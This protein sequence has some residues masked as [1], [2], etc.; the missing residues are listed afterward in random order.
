MA[1]ATIPLRLNDK[2]QATPEAALRAAMEAL[3]A[4]RIDYTGMTEE[5]IGRLRRLAAS[6]TENASH[7]ISRARR[8]FVDQKVARV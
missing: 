7:V 3:N 5:E 2:G 6:L 4:V 1:V 8:E